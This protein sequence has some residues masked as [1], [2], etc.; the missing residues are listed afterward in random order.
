VVAQAGYCSISHIQRHLSVGYNKAAKLVE[1][2]ETE[3]VVGPASGKAG[4]RREVFIEA[5]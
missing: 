1:Q 4:G 2:M 5:R 3:G